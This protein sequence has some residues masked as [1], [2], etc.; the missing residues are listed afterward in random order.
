MILKTAFEKLFKIREEAGR[1]RPGADEGFDAHEKPFL[2]HL[3]DLRMTIMKIAITLTIF[4][5][6]A[7]TFHQQIF[8]L[9]QWPARITEVSPGVSL[10]ERTEFITLAPQEML[11]LMLKVSFFAGI[12]VSFP[13]I[14]YF[15]FQFI[16]PG[17]RQAEKRA[18]IPGALVGF[19]LFLGGVAFAFFLATPIALKFFYVFENERISEIDPGREAMRKPVAELPL[20]GIDGKEY[21]P[22]NA[23]T[24]EDPEAK[25]EETAEAPL[26]TLSPEMKAD[27]RTY[28]TQLFTVQEGTNL[29]LRYDKDRDKVVI[30]QVKGGS[31]VLQIG[32]YIK[33]VTRLVLVFGISFQLP[34]VVS[35]L[36][37]LELLTARVM[38]STR[39][40]A[41]IIILVSSAILTPPDIMTLGLL[42]GPMIILYE[43]CIVIASVIERNREKRRAAEEASYRKRMAELHE[44]PADDLTDEE[45]AELHKEEIAL[46]EKEHANLYQDENEHVPY[47]P[48]HGDSE[49]DEGWHDDHGHWHHGD[50]PDHDE[51][52]H[53]DPHHGDDDHAPIQDWPDRET[54]TEDGME[55]DHAE[56]EHESSSA[57]PEG[58]ETDTEEKQDEDDFFSDDGC[59]PEGPVIDLN[60]AEQFELETLPGVGPKLAEI[61]I[62]NR[63]YETF[64]D[65]ERVPGIGPSKL[66]KMM[67]RLMLG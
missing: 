54:L 56:V 4:T 25:P 53:D 15:L 26:L 38:R 31:S 32:E 41:W 43:I 17:L 47:D 64:D 21:K 55:S 20:I 60:H 22:L 29:A 3:E 18:V 35:I 11:M 50:H 24:T 66:A 36:V 42:A 14:I 40:Y 46:Y 10:W 30:L 34:V 63:P 65:V 37:K 16:L 8:D 52:H 13:I 67:D 45:K 44:K 49:H 12:I 51:Y 5:I 28:V 1:A 19:L 2:D 48:H 23:E 27:I 7:F 9:V 58:S 39:S 57:S 62:N 33:F 61:I 59:D 6:A